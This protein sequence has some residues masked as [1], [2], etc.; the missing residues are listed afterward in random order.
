MVLHACA[1]SVF[2]PGTPGLPSVGMEAMLEWGGGGGLAGTRGPP[3][4][5]RC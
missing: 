4:L 1:E 5:F 2:A 3:L